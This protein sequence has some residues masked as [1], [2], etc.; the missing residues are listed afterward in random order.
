MNLPALHVLN[1]LVFIM[2]G[3]G[4]SLPLVAVATGKQIGE[5]RNDKGRN[6]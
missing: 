1:L 5:T 4:H 2:G 3:K 6:C